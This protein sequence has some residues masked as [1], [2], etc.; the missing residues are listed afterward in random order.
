MLFIKDDIRS[1]LLSIEKN[2]IEV[3]YVNPRKI[4][5]LLCGSYNPNKN[6]IHAHLENVDR[7]L[8]LYS[9]SYENHIG[10]FNVRRENSYILTNLIKDPTCFKN[11]ENPSYADFILTN[12]PRN[13]CYWGFSDFHK[14]TL[15]V[16]KNSLLEYKP[17]LIK[18]W[19]DRHF[20]KNTFREDS[21]SERLNFDIEINDKNFTAFF[22]T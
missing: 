18:F 6:N 21:L 14:M 7:S 1:K 3:F 22:E 17:R 12:R 2:S 9:S 15:T 8:A 11:P 16:M 5:W 20:Q 4:K 10:D 19:D 13:L